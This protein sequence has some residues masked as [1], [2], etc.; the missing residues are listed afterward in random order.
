[1]KNKTIISLLICLIAVSSMTVVSASM[2]IYR[3]AFSTNG[4]LDDLTYASIDV[5]SSH[6]GENVI[7]QIYYSQTVTSDGFIN[8]RSADAYRFFPDHAEINIYD[9]NN[10]L[11]TTQSVSLSAESGIQ[12][13]GAGDYDH[14]YISGS[15]T[16]S[17]S[18]SSSTS[19]GS[20]YHSG[21]SDSYVANSDTGKFHAPGCGDVD[22]MD[23]SNKVY[24]SSRSE[25]LSCGYDPCGHCNP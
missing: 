4:G 11:I 13:F 16:S 18:Y 9:T 17:S 3:G 12:T 21:T 1:M 10:N 22:K 20:S 5:G 6:S 7:M 2:D 19:G 24:F 8:I 23:P 25:A 14:S 15:D